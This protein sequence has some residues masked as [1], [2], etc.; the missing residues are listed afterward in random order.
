MRIPIRFTQLCREALIMVDIHCIQSIEGWTEYYV[1]IGSIFLEEYEMKHYSPRASFEKRKDVEQ[2]LLT[3]ILSSLRV[4][5]AQLQASFS[6]DTVVGLTT[7]AGKV[8]MGKFVVRSIG[9]RAFREKVIEEYGL[10]YD[11]PVLWLIVQAM[12]DA[13]VIESQPSSLTSTLTKTLKEYAKDTLKFAWNEGGL[14]DEVHAELVREFGEAAGDALFGEAAAFVPIIGTIISC[15]RGHQ[16]AIE[17]LDAIIEST[18][19]VARRVHESIVIP[20]VLE[21]LG[22]GLKHIQVCSSSCL[23][24]YS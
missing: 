22:L 18:Q 6:Y 19:N 9:A 15:I 21:R 4:K 2:Y 12:L 14:Q 16:Q 23:R 8:P 10:K 1:E 24:C 5:A 7:I 11:E 13:G 17:K 3:Q 20:V